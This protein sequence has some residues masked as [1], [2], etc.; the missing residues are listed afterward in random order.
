[1]TRRKFPTPAGRVRLELTEADELALHAFRNFLSWG[2]HP[3]DAHAPL[4]AGRPVPPAWWAYAFG[5]SRWCPPR[6]EW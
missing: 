2:V 4:D 6:G 3:L 5:A 1:M